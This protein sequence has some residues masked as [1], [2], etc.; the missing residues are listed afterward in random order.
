MNKRGFELAVRT[1]VIIVL[2]LLILLAL[3]LAFTSSFKRFWQEIKGYFTSDVEAV[4]KSC[5]NSCVMENKYDFC[6]LKRKVNF[7]ESREKITCLDERL[8]I[9]CDI[10]CREVCVK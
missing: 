10:D 2:A 9:K 6:C 3:S 1:L 5:Q 7:N 4:I 8:K